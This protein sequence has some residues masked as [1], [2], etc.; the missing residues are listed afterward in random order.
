MVDNLQYNLLD[1]WIKIHVIVICW[2]TLRVR[3]YVN[4][5]HPFQEWLGNI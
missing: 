4:N 2:E 5:P 3:V 1:L